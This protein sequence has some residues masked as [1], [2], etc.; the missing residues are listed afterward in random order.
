VNQVARIEG[1][2][3]LVQQ[4]V[5]ADKSVASFDEE[6][7]KSTGMHKLDGVLEPVELFAFQTQ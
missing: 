3:K 5:L 2:T 7:W 6:R 1:M 4:T